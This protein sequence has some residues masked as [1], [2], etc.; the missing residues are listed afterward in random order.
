MKRSFLV[1]IE[2]AVLVQHMLRSRISGNSVGNGRY[3]DPGKTYLSVIYEVGWEKEL[4]YHRGKEQQA[5]SA[6]FINGEQMGRAGVWGENVWEMRAGEKRW[7]RNDASLQEHGK[8]D[9]CSSP[10]ELNDGGAYQS[11]ES[12]DL[13]ESWKHKE[14]LSTAR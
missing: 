1:T 14:P 5:S 2:K 8:M 3:E 10:P 13:W 7:R 6:V 11:T 4:G 9:S 12:S